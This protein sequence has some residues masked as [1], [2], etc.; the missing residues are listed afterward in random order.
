MWGVAVR[1]YA[2][3]RKGHALSKP[4][5]QETS[6]QINLV[7]DPVPAGITSTFS[8]S[9]ARPIYKMKAIFIPTVLNLPVF[10]RHPFQIHHVQLQENDPQSIE[11][12]RQG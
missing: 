11:W 1:T 5:S 8:K 12:A 2:R 6:F 4:V 9:R 3:I 7:H 10:G